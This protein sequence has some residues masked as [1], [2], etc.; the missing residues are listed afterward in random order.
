MLELTGIGGVILLA[1][2]IW[3]LVAIFSSGASAGAKLL[4]A[5]IVIA[6]PLLGLIL[7]FLMGPKSVRV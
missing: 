6:L 2:D 4:W 7:W 3:A 5:I 1:L